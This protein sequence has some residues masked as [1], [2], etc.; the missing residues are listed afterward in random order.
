MSNVAAGVISEVKSGRECC[1]L[2]V[3]LEPSIDQLCWPGLTLWRFISCACARNEVLLQVDIGLLQLLPLF[4]L[5]L[6]PFK[7]SLN[8]C[9]KSL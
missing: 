2:S 5:V 6:S 1:D 8:F 9:A 3:Q 4:Q 7:F